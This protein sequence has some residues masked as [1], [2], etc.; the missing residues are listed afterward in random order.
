MQFS[1]IENRVYTKILN[2]L[3]LIFHTKTINYNSLDIE[4]IWMILE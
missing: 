2:V 3:K 1:K 4:I